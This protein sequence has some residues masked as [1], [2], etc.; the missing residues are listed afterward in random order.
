MRHLLLAALLYAA[1]LASWAQ[2]YN[3]TVAYTKMSG[4]TLS[5]FLANEDGSRAVPVYSTK[6]A[7]GAIDIA[8]GGGRIAFS[9]PDGLRVLSYTA[10]NSGIAVGSI[11]LLDSGIVGAVDF[12]P[13]GSRIIYAVHPTTASTKEIRVVSATGGAHTTLMTGDNGNTVIGEDVAWLRSGVSFVFT[14]HFASDLRT[15]LRGASVDSWGGVTPWPTPLL[16]TAGEISEI[17]EVSTART[18]DAVLTRLSGT[19]GLPTI[20]E[21]DIASGTLTPH[22][23]GLRGRFSSAD[24]SIVF[25]DAGFVSRYTI[26]SGTTTRLTKRGAFGKIDT[27]PPPP[28]P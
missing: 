6:K 25:V 3:P 26:A 2:A 19:F 7:I 14:Q 28:A 23:T 21:Y 20:F 12:S 11:T 22:V 17:A 5:I 10:S 1:S 24:S 18:K 8:P 4:T 9:Q 13:D 15:E 16:V 27:R